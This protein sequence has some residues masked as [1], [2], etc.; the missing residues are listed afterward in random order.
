MYA[1]K[2]F[3]PDKARVQL[4]LDWQTVYSAVTI[5]HY[6]ARRDWPAPNHCMVGLCC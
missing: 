5:V 6:E 1:E 3:K 2:R 4:G